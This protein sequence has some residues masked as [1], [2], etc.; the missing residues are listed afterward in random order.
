M[1]LTR[2]RKEEMLEGYRTLV[3]KSRG[4]VLTSFSGL[5][6]KQLEAL[7]RR[8][9]EAGGEFHVVKNSLIRLAFQQAGLPLPETAG[10]G[11][12]AIGFGAEDLPA[13]VKAVVEAARESEGLK[14]KGGVL[15]GVLYSAA[16]VQ[17][18]ADLPALPV[19]RARLLAVVQAPAGRVAGSLAGSIRQLVRVIQARSEQEVAPAA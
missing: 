3:G 13:L 5:S 17:R 4:Y 12:T 19:V 11:T 9:R 10:E 14:L 2:K 16:Q 1:A 6:V 8:V 15:E 7:R 18:L